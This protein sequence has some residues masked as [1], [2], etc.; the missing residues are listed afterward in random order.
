[1]LQWLKELPTGRQMSAFWALAV[2]LPVLLLPMT[3]FLLDA[4][5]VGISGAIFGIA[6]VA[7]YLSLSVGALIYVIVRRR[8]LT[9]VELANCW[10][11]MAPGVMVLLLGCAF[12]ILDARLTWAKEDVA[13]ALLVVGQVFIAMVPPALAILRRKTAGWGEVAV[14][15]LGAA[16]AALCAFSLLTNSSRPWDG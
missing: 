3:W 13:F 6:A 5:S 12:L 2:L 16:L 15:G 1:M 8:G 9:G 14:L 10:L 7:A 4:F 11:G